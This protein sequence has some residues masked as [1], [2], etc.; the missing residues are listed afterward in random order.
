MKNEQNKKNDKT[1]GLSPCHMD[2][3]E[4]VSGGDL[5]GNA[6][7]KCR[8][9]GYVIHWAGRG[10]HGVYECPECHEIELVQID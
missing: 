2:D 8:K 6:T 9:C 4:N 7:M 1:A 10:Y 5:L 3:L